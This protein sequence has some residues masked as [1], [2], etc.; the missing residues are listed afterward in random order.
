MEKVQILVDKSKAN[1]SFQMWYQKTDDKRKFRIQ[2][3]AWKDLQDRFIGL[4]VSR[5]I[6]NVSDF[7]DAFP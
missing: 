5:T 4:I 1:V 7:T 6:Y 2:D 3:L